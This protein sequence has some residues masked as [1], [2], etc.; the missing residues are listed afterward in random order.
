[1]HPSL[2]SLVHEQHRAD[3]HRA[4]ARSRLVQRA[5]ATAPRRFRRRS[6][7]TGVRLGVIESFLR[8][9]QRARASPHG[10]VMVQ[11]TPVIDS[12]WSVS[13][14]RATSCGSRGTRIGDVHDNGM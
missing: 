4:A 14:C 8:A 7:A 1:M 12:H 6:D 9:S 5:R 2:A 13:S 11:V 10:R 3:L